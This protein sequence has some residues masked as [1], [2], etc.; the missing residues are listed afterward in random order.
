MKL[1]FIIDIAHRGSQTATMNF[2]KGP[3]FL[4]TTALLLGGCADN[5]IDTP[6]D[7]SATDAGLTNPKIQHSDLNGVTT[8]I[9]DA[10]DKSQWVFLDLDDRA[11]P[12]ADGQGK[13][14]WDLA[15]RRVKVHLNGGINGDGNVQGQFVEGQGVFDAT[16]SAPSGTFETDQAVEHD[17]NT[18]PF[19]EAGLLFGFWYDYA[20]QGHVVTPKPRAYIIQSNKGALFKLQILDYYNQAKSPAIITIKWARLPTQEQL[21]L[22]ALLDTPPSAEDGGAKIIA[23]LDEPSRH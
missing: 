12:A 20:P 5:L 10:S 9:I 11:Y 16:N 23:V 3:G 7:A 13:G 19:Q 2:S 22:Y 17:P 1:K 21:H 14:A 6:P 18:D 15:F 4:L 8:T